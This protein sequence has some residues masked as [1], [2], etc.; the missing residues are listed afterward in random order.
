LTDHLGTIDRPTPPRSPNH[1]RKPFS[2]TRSALRAQLP[3]A[4]GAY[5]TPASAPRLT[6]TAYLTR[7]M[8]RP[9]ESSERGVLPNLP[10]REDTHGLAGR[11]RAHYWSLPPHRP[12]SRAERRRSLR[13]VVTMCTLFGAR[14]HNHHIPAERSARRSRGVP[15]GSGR[16]CGRGCGPRALAWRPRKPRRSR[17]RATGWPAQNVRPTG[18]L[19]TD[20]EADWTS[21]RI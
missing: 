3:S 19:R 21:E 6:R 12:L 14:C 17:S 4:V 15:D 10:G 8:P 1:P 7:P 13:M 11:D 9:T 18:Y 20:I 2:S 16:G 5:R